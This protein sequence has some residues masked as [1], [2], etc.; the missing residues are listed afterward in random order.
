MPLLPP[1]YQ[2]S[3]SWCRLASHGM[4]SSSVNGMFACIFCLLAAEWKSSASANCQPVS[5]ASSSP[6]VVLP[7]PVTPMSTR[8]MSSFAATLGQNLPCAQAQGN[9]ALWGSALGQTVL[10]EG[11]LDAVNHGGG[12]P[13]VA[14]IPAKDLAAGSDDGGGEGGGECVV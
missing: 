10:G 5:A 4:R 2:P 1:S 11:Q 8:I 3:R 13:V 12:G 14:R 9:C 6:T 7:E